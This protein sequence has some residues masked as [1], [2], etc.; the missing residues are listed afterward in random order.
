MAEFHTPEHAVE[1]L[2]RLCECGI[3]TL[4]A[5]AD[6]HRV[7]YWLELFRRQG[8]EIQ[9]IA[10]TASEM[11][12]VF[13]NIRITAAAGAIGIYHHG[14]QTDRWWVEGCIDRVE[15][16]LKCIRDQGVQVGLATHHP[17]VI[18]YAEEKGWDLDFYMACFYNVNRRIRES[19][20]VAN[21]MAIELTGEDDSVPTVDEEFLD[22]DPPR[23]VKVI[24]AVQKQ[25][26]AFKILGAGRRCADQ[27]HVR[28]AF[29]YAY[30]NIKPHDVAVV[31]MWQK[32]HDEVALNVAH[33]NV[34]LQ[35]TTS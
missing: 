7:L 33:A 34:A 13:Q 11:H 6:Y 18:E 35:D 30:T 14:S 10:Q 29:R 22:D 8:G 12:D 27:E 26:F 9:W 1:Y 20:I 17:E 28:D 25:C 15:D 31:G 4:L 24:Q 2:K 3:D 32:H 23:M 5:R 16:F 19:D 21:R